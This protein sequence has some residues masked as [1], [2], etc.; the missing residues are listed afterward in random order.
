MRFRIAPSLLALM[1]ILAVQTSSLA[2]TITFDYT[3]GIKDTMVSNFWPNNN[4][5]GQQLAYVYN[6]SN[7]KMQ[8]LIQFEGLFGD[9][10]GQIP[11]GSTINNATLRMY[12][13]GVQTPSQQVGVYNMTSNWEESSTWNSL[14]GGVRPG[15]NAQSDPVTTFTD[16]STG[17]L[18]IDVAPSLQAWANG[19]SSNLGW[20]LSAVSSGYSFASFK[21]SN[22]SS[23]EYRPILSVDFTPAA[24]EAPEPGTLMLMSSSL[25]GFLGWRLRRRRGR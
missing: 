11:L 16:L 6:N 12:L 7:W 23:A 21:T 22:Y 10:A 3:T 24:S 2:N 25:A 18:G 8:S 5:G 14:G 1:L 13:Y 4:M 9:A 19:S 17:F 15:D 20:A